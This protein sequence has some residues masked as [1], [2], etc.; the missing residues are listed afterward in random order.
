MLELVPPS[1]LE[2]KIPVLQHV[3]RSHPDPCKHHLAEGCHHSENICYTPPKPRKG[4]SNTNKKKKV[5]YIKDGCVSYTTCEDVPEGEHVM[6]DI[7]SLNDHPIRVLFDSGASHTFLSK[8][9]AD[10]HGLKID[11]VN[12]SYK[13]QS[14]DGQIITNQ[15]ARKVPINL[16]GRIFPT[17]LSFSHIKGLIS[18]W[19]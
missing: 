1:Q 19:V 17:N 15:M 4:S 7:F 8:A 5:S 18:Y 14:P 3:F 11:C 16:A 9:C 6:E 2:Q 10:R 12:T 13:I